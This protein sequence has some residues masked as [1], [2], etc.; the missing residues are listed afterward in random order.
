[1]AAARF[2]GSNLLSALAGALF[3]LYLQQFVGEPRRLSRLDLEPLPVRPEWNKSVL[4]GNIVDQKIALVVNPH[5]GLHAFALGANGSIWHKYQTS[6][7]NMSGLMPK[8]V[9]SEWHVLTPNASLIFG[10]DPVV[11]LNADGR[12]ELLVGYKKDSLDIWQM[13]QTDAK[14]PLAWSKPRGPACMCEDPDPSKCPWCM[15]CADRPECDEQYW[16]KSFPFTTS[17]MSMML[18]PTDN[19]LKL[20]YRSFDGFLYRMEQ[21]KPGYSKKWTDSAVQFGFFE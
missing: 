2:I 15:T 17:D 21:Q 19:K 13:Y 18:D 8:A 16:L 10:N 12:I 4:P 1:M 11:A 3:V 9:M 7:V 20:Y 5:Y 14:D 6:P